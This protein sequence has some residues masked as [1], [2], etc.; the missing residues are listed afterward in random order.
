[1]VILLAHCNN[2]A[3]AHYKS[4][5]RIRQARGEITVPLSVLSLATSREDLLQRSLMG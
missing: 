2:C 5:E 1:M 4:V 3:L